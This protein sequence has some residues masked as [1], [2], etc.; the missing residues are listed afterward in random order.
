MSTLAEQ[1]RWMD[2]IDQAALVA[3]G[4]VSPSELLEA[5]IE[6]I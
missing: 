4:Q 1:T 5:A 3:S 6:R 2:A